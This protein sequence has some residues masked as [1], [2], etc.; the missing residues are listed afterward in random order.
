MA[1][2]GREQN[3]VEKKGTKEY[4]FNITEGKENDNKERN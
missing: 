4:F 1:G 3:V 2:N